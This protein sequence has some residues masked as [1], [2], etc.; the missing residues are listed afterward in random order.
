MIPH[1]VVRCHHWSASPVCCHAVPKRGLL[2]IG[3]SASVC[4]PTSAR[5]SKARSRSLPSCLKAW[6]Y[7]PASFFS[8]GRCNQSVLPCQASPGLVRPLL[9]GWPARLP[10]RCSGASPVCAGGAGAGVHCSDMV[11]DLSSGR[12]GA[13]MVLPSSWTTWRFCVRG[14]KAH[15]CVSSGVP[16]LPAPLLEGYMAL[17]LTGVHGSVLLVRML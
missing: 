6:L 10:V 13:G 2:D 9:Y 11:C 7:L 4:V 17:V 15:L 14:G 1:C 16:S 8:L 3:C 5:A 12:A